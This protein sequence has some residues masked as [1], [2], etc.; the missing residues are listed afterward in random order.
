MK[1]PLQ[2]YQEQINNGLIKED[3]R[4]ISILEY[5]NKIQADLIAEHKRRQQLFFILSKPKL[6]K[7]LYLWGE[8]GIGKTFLMDCF[9]QALPFN[10][11]ARIHFHLFMQHIHQQLKLHQGKKDPLVIIAKELA[12][13]T[14]VLCFDELIVNDI[15]DAMLLARLF[16]HIFQEGICLVATSNVI[17]DDLYKKGLQR[18]LFLPTI[19][20]IKENTHVVHLP[21]LIDYRLHSLKNTYA[22]YTPNDSYAHENMQRIFD[23]LAQNEVINDKYILLNERLVPVIKATDHVV[24]FD[25]SNILRIPRSQQDYIAISTKYHTVFISNLPVIAANDRDKITLLIRLVDVFYD[26]KTRL[27]LSSAVPIDKIY[28]SGPMQFEFART[29]SRLT[30]MQSEKYFAR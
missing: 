16:K 3:A 10:E 5:F 12:K 2:Y 26:A 21:S 15:A 20:L 1:T 14:L 22:F 13:K 30:E 29:R 23:F 8:V 27:I 9:F 19:A 17:P 11:K 6:V 18:E 7:G 24:W 4:Q 28:A 25:F